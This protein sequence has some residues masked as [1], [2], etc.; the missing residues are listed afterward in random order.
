[1]K[2]QELQTYLEKHGSAPI[3]QVIRYS[4]PAVRVGSKFVPQD[5]KKKQDKKDENK[6]NS[7]G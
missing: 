3:E 2:I 7:A 6:A 1:M 4:I 5:E